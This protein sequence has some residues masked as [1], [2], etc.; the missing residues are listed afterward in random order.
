MKIGFCFLVKENISKENLWR[1]FLK[2][3]NIDD[4]SVYIHSKSSHVPSSLKNVVVDPHPIETAWASISLVHATKRLLETAFN[5][6][7]DSVIFLSGDSLPLWNFQTIQQLCSR[8]LFSLQPKQDLYP[9]QIKM[10][11]REFERIRTFYNLEK[12]VQ[13][14][15]QNMFFS[16]SKLDYNAVKNVQ[17]EK[18]PCQEVPDEYFWANQLI[19]SGIS[20]QNSNYIYVNDDPTKT[21]SLSWVLDEEI[22]HNARSRGCL[23]IRKVNGFSSDFARQYYKSL[24]A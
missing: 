21:Q 19:L 23:F 5:D 3:A 8:T 1:N 9:F 2:S 16:L 14:V 13:L 18:F 22:I 17:I 20:V 12:T 11:Q 15:K 24:I 6:D 7:C 4:Y 10:N